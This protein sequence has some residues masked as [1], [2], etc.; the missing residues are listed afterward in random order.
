MHAQV[1]AMIEEELD[2]A[3]E[4]RNLETVAGAFAGDPAVSFPTVVPELSTRRVLTTTFVEGIKVSRL[5]ELDRAGLDRQRVAESIL[6]AYCRM[7][8]EH[9]TYHADPHPGNLFVLPGGAIAFVDFGAVGR[10]SQEMREG[11]PEFLSGVLAHDTTRILAALRRMGFVARDGDERAAERVVAYFQRRFLE[12]IT[13]D[14][15]HLDEIHIDAGL[16]LETLADLRRLDVSL[17]DLMEIFEVPRD[18]V[19]LERT[20]L[21]LVG[22]CTHLAPAMNP[23]T[24]IRPHLERL[25]LGR[26]RTWAQ[27]AA[28]AVKDLAVAAVALPGELRRLLA[29][30]ERGDLEI[31]LTGLRAGAERL[32]AAAHQLLYGLFATTAA[33]VAYLAHASADATLAR[34]AGGVA[35]LALV[36]LLGSIWRTA[37][38]RRR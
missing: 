9:G 12:E 38:H 3:R 31:R 16:K 24:I 30:A 35:T 28:A 33:L 37:R 27:V 25:M 32:Y 10:L 22:L 5:A 29:R 36:L 21:L 26:D 19:L 20:L 23:L 6:T 14:S 8:F 1:R 18:W 34:L 13:R 17:R 11:I 2:F 4:A 7:I 15:W